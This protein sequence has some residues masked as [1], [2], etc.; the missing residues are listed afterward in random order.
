M[1]EKNSASE[2][3]SDKRFSFGRN[4][5]EFLSDLDA[6]QLEHASQS[7]QERLGP[8]LEGKTFLDVGSGSGIFS[9]AAY[10]LGAQ[11]HSF[12]YDPHSVSCAETLRRA[13]KQTDRWTI[14]RGSV[15]DKQY[16]DGLGQ[17]DVTY[18]WGVLHHTGNMWAALENV[19]GLV[20]PGGLLWI[21]IYNDQGFAS[22][23]WREVKRLYNTLP[24][25]LRPPLVALAMLRLWGPTVIKDALRGSPLK[26]WRTYGR[27]RG[28][29]PWRDAVDW[30]GGFPFEVSRPEEILRFYEARGFSAEWCFDAAK[31]LGCNEFIFRRSLP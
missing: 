2:P 9:M 16:L 27:N 7:L 18:S 17:F 29:S 31:G 19:A 22:S 4:W 25:F 3:I 13:I 30:V 21:A 6:V 12:D 15:L 20:R 5:A 23:V 10:H 28:M 11:V 8:S 1:S 26:S 14:E 24:R